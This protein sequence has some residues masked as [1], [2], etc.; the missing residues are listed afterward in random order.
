MRIIH[1]LILIVLLF[2]IN[3]YAEPD[4]SPNAENWVAYCIKHKVTRGNVCF[5]S[6]I[7]WDEEDGI[8][9]ILNPKP[10]SSEKFTL[11]YG[12]ID[13]FH[14]GGSME[15]KIDDN[16]AIFLDKVEVNSRGEKNKNV[17]NHAS[18]N[19]S[20]VFIRQLK[21]GKSGVGS[22]G[23]AKFSFTLKGFTK[24]FGKIEK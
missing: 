20:K 1:F 12:G 15:F 17:S 7:P 3:V 8:I 22:C 24:A 11:S 18:Y 4:S 13:G 9:V 5:S 19:V 21:A 10:D 6:I 23:N 2:P 16:G 14:C